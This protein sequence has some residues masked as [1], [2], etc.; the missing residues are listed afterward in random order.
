[1]EEMS[2]GC[3]QSAVFVLEGGVG[4]CPLSGQHHLRWRDGPWGFS[5]LDRRLGR[6]LC[7]GLW[8][9]WGPR[10]CPSHLSHCRASRQQLCGRVPV[11]GRPSRRPGWGQ[12][13][14]ASGLSAPPL[15]T[16]HPGPRAHPLPSWRLDGHAV[17]T[18]FLTTS[19]TS[20]RYF[21]LPEPGPFS[22]KPKLVSSGWEREGRRTR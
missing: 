13:R 1:M 5:K 16:P 11:P 9:A 12:S 2:G 19:V 17:L 3:F 8:P 14:A 15:P 18:L 4:I 6:S 20:A 7:S 10:K 22:R 21:S